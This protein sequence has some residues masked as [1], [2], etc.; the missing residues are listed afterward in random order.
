[1]ATP[2]KCK[3]TG[4]VKHISGCGKLAYER[5]FGLCM[6]CRNKWLASND[7][8]AQEYLLKRIIPKAKRK[9]ETDKKVIEKEKKG[10]SMEVKKKNVLFINRME[11]L[12]YVRYFKPFRRKFSGSFCN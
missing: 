10:G 4:R 3:G 8:E 12:S 2:K 9:I 7:P 1:M 11:I 6:P 5:E